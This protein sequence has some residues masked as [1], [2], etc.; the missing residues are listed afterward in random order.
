MS[1]PAVTT[2]APVDRRRALTAL[3]LAWVFPGLGH[4]YI[5]RRRGAIAYAPIV[6]ATCLLGRSFEGRLDGYATP[7]R[8]LQVPVRF[9]EHELVTPGTVAAAH[10][11]D[12]E[13][14]VWTI[15]DT[16]EM[17]RLLRLGVDGVM[18]DFPRRLR[19]V[20]IQHRSVGG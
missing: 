20:T 11:F 15:N 19:D 4:Y 12:L 8:A 13:M 2:A 9:G 10:R 6:T 18:S 14:H 3:L 1:A 16:A 5:G 7:G 17:E